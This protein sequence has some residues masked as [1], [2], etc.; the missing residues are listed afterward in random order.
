MKARNSIH[1]RGFTLVELMVVVVIILV[2]GS[3]A[4]VATKSVKSR[5]DQAVCANNMRQIGIALQAYADDHGEYPSTAHSERL[6]RSWIYELESYLG[7]F[8]ELRV[9]PADPNAEERLREHGTS[10]VLN[11]FVFV[12]RIDPFGNPIGTRMNRPRALKDPSRTLLAFCCA[13]HTPAGPGNDHTHSER[14]T[15][16]SAVTRDIAP[17]RHGGKR[18]NYLYA[19]GRVVTW[20]QEELKR[21]IESGTNFAKPPGYIE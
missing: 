10:Y 16:W 6:D 15:S 3:L 19:D 12:P 18:A 20:N 9:C 4:F 14:W 8:D 11:S 17:D 13:D 2:L 7:D 1:L 21:E 5:V